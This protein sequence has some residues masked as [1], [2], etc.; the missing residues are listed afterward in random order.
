MSRCISWRGG[1]GLKA[2]RISIEG[3]V[4][5]SIDRILYVNY[6]LVTV[7]IVIMLVYL[8]L[9]NRRMMLSFKL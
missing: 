3:K 1:N 7:T 5:N 9:A 6:A 8:G 2:S 4:I